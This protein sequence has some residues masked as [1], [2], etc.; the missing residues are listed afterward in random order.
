MTHV[1]STTRGN[2]GGRIPDILG[3][4]R[5]CVEVDAPVLWVQRPRHVEW[6]EPSRPLIRAVIDVR[7]AGAVSITGLAA[8]RAP[9]YVHA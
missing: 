2:R 4:A 3:T 1:G 9:L 7:N 8:N 6:F 5:R